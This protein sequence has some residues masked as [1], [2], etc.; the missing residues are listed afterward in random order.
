MQLE[1]KLAEFQRLPYEEKRKMCINIL[2]VLEQKGNEQAWR[3]LTT[4][5]SL[6]PI[7][8]SLLESIFKDFETSIEKIQEGKSQERLY[9]FE[10]SKDI[11]TQI[12]AKEEEDRV[13]ENADGVLEWL[14][15][16]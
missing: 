9:M 7:P 4:T 15:D 8:E 13:S 2:T 16:I 1:Q 14:D 12:R 5:Q 6:D 3:I 10:K 11:M